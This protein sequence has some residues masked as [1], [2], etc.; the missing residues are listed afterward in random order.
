VRNRGFVEAMAQ[1]GPS[2]TRLALAVL[3][4]RADYGDG[5]RCAIALS[6]TRQVSATLAVAVNGER[7]TANF[8]PTAD[9]LLVGLISGLPIGNWT[10]LFRATAEAAC[11]RRPERQATSI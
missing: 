4:R 6:G 5:R 9:G 1:G 7:L 3:S 11:V 2:G 8:K 10:C